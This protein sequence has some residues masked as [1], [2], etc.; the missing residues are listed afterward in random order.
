[1]TDQP[2]PTFRVELLVLG[3]RVTVEAPQPEGPLR[4]DDALPFFREI[5][6]QAVTLAVRRT[7]EGGRT[8]SCRKGCS[9]CCRVQPVPV[10]PPEAYALLRLV[11]ALPEPRRDEIRRRFADRVERLR[12]AGLMAPYLHREGVTMAEQAREVTGRYIALGLACPFLEDDACGIYADR[13]FVC[14]QYLVTS[15]PELCRDPLNNPV[16]VVPMPV[17]AA[18]AALRAAEQALGRPQFTVPLALALEYAAEHRDELERAFPA[19]ELLR[20]WL[21]AL[22]GRTPRENADS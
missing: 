14:R 6:D 4:L 5:D 21:A 13:P 16:E 17:A 3:E 9:A 15:P 1:M 19:Q 12:Q 22:L 10:T 7:E 20:G 2:R 11:E 8:I 18:G